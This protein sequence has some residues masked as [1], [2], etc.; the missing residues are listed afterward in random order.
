VSY[1]LDVCCCLPKDTSPLVRGGVF[2][3]IVILSY[4]HWVYN[5]NIFLTYLNKR[6][7]KL[8]VF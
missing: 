6:Q 1:E 5:N 3:H 4:C 7:A 8:F 2:C